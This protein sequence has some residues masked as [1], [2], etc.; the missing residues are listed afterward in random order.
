MVKDRRKALTKPVGDG[1]FRRLEA[2][3][4]VMQQRMSRLVRV[5]DESYN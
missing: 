2:K 1:T 3:A 5:L 4:L